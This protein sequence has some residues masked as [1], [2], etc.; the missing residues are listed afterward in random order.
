MARPSSDQGRDDVLLVG[1]EAPPRHGRRLAR[2]VASEEVDEH[3]RARAQ[4]AD[5]SGRFGEPTKLV[6]VRL[7]PEVIAGHAASQ[8]DRP[9]ARKAGEA[10][11]QAVLRAEL[12]LAPAVGR[13]HARR[14]ARVDAGAVAKNPR[15]VGVLQGLVRRV[16][17]RWIKVA[18]QHILAL[19]VLSVH[20]QARR[21]ATFRTSTGS[22]GA[23]AIA[24]TGTGTGIGGGAARKDEQHGCR[25]HNTRR[26]VHH[27]GG[28]H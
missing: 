12:G 15:E 14:A 1:L 2:H 22:T 18:G 9:R 19:P 20:G 21:G 16:V 5:P 6:G 7:V 3:E 28:A 11:R 27:G 10:R 24:I 8:R 25:G 26:D 13:A 17:Q 4:L 23:I